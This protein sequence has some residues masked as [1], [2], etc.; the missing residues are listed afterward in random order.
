MGDIP[1]T[2]YRERVMG[3]SKDP[4]FRL[5]RFPDHSPPCL[6]SPGVGPLE[7]A[8]VTSLICLASVSQ[9]QAMPIRLY[10]RGLSE[11]AECV[12]L[13]GTVRD[14]SD[15]GGLIHTHLTFFAIFV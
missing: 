2:R 4:S 1:A 7:G 11:L 10:F 5:L 12:C 6:M 3:E 8:Q 13:P 9:L 15:E 14:E